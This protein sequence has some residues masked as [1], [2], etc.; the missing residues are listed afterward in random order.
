[1]PNNFTD[2]GPAYQNPLMGPSGYSNVPNT[3][4][5]TQPAPQATQPSGV[6]PTSPLSQPQVNSAPAA[7]ANGQ[8]ISPSALQQAILQAVNGNGANGTVGSMDSSLQTYLQNAGIPSGDISSLINAGM[9]SAFPNA[10]NNSSH[11]LQDANG[12]NSQAMYNA[13]YGGMQPD[14]NNL[15]GNTLAGTSTSNPTGTSTNTSQNVAGALN[16]LLTPQYIYPNGVPTSS[17]ATINQVPTSNINLSN[18]QYAS[19]ILQMLQP[20][21]Q[22]QDQALQNQLAASGVVGGPSAQALAQLQSQQQ[23]TFQGDIQPELLQQESLNLQQNQGNA[24]NQMTALTQ[25]ANAQNANNQFNTSDAIKNAEFNSSLQSGDASTLAQL[26]YNQWAQSGDWQYGLATGAAGAQTGA[27]QPIYQQP[28]P[29]NFS[30]LG[31]SFAP[32]PTYTNNSSTYNY[33]GSNPIDSLPTGDY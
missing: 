9:S 26:L 14:V 10:Y 7:T 11:V 19:S 22:T 13:I 15:N 16:T 23:Q 5:A 12:G 18:P 4:V 1:M 31:S 17:T 20:Q 29:V 2:S 32:T 6:A 8:V 24:A 25:N 21:F 33:S 3:G 27:Y 30:S 28:Q